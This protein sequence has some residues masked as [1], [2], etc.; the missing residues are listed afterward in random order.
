V[1]EYRNAEKADYES[2]VFKWDDGGGQ[3]VMLEYRNAEKAGAH[4]YGTQRYEPTP[5]SSDI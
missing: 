3:S 5:A 2:D 4:E 1:L